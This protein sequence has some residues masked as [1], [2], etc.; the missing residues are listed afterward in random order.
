MLSELE[1][2]ASLERLSVTS[3]S[4]RCGN[5]CAISMFRLPPAVSDDPKLFELM[6]MSNKRE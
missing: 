5:V 3:M 2:P 4:S 1:R 6:G